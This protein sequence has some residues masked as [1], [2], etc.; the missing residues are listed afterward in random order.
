MAEHARARLGPTGPGPLYE[1]NVWISSAENQTPSHNAP[2]IRSPSYFHVRLLSRPPRC[3]S[4]CTRARRWTDLRS[5]TPA[6]LCSAHERMASLS[7]RSSMALSGEGGVGPLLAIYAATRRR[8][9]GDRS[10]PLVS[11][12]S[13]FLFAGLFVDWRMG[14]SQRNC[15]MKEASSKIFPRWTRRICSSSWN[16]AVAACSQLVSRGRLRRGEA[17]RDASMM[18]CHQT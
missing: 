10:T 3:A 13:C 17:G 5:T 12:L 15:S 11:G 7:R 6:T 1:T 14:D 4:S 8:A 2:L 9:R 18:T 16:T